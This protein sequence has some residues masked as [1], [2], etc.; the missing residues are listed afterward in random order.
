[1]AQLTLVLGEGRWLSFHTKE[2]LI[3]VTH[4]TSSGKEVKKE[5]LATLGFLEKN[6]CIHLRDFL[7]CNIANPPPVGNEF[8][9]GFATVFLP[10]AVELVEMMRKS[11]Q[12]E[13]E[14]V[15]GKAESQEGD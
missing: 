2:D 7:A 13:S 6:D 4:I 11:L 15:A 14:S 12:E 5:K 8:F 3:E 1:M 10:I 9:K